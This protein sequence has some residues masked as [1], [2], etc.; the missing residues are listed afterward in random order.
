MARP[1]QLFGGRFDYEVARC[2]GRGVDGISQPPTADHN[3]GEA[4]DHHHDD[5]RDDHPGCT[6]TQHDDG[7][8]EPHNA[9]DRQA[10]AING[11]VSREWRGGLHGGHTRR[12]RR[13]GIPG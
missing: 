2:V 9:D 4:E 13:T 11:E 1:S 6:S 10:D 12:S 3:L 7:R 8:H 5:P